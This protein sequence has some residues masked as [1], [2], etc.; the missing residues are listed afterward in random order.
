MKYKVP[1]KRY[2]L[3]SYV[4]SI[5][6]LLIAIVWITPLIMTFLTSFKTNLDV[7]KF[8]KNYNLLPTEWVTT[9]Y[10]SVLE[11]PGTPFFKVTLNTL[12][13][14]AS[15]I[16]G[17]LFI[18]TT[19]AFAFE[20]LSFRGSDTIFWV[21]LAL[22]MIPNVVALVPQY[23]FYTTIGW[24]DHLP[25]IIAP[26]LA[27][28][29]NVFLVRNFMKGVPMEYDEAARIDGASEFYIYSRIMLPMINPVLMVL[30]LFSFNR[31]WNDFMWP[32]IAITTPERSTITPSIRML[33]D[34]FGGRPELLLAGCILAMIPTFLI[35]LFCQKYFLKGLQLG[36][37]VKG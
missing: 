14:S 37:G 22:S 24:I 4:I 16:V 2:G 28:L 33:N 1:R 15:V 21:L 10:K 31:A 7:K 17:V 30:V 9:N 34:S 19:S 6:L 20:R 18:S 32:T 26:L 3:G 27:N 11:Y 13:V 36:A 5:V 8:V 35:F 29:F 25:S 12:I 23:N